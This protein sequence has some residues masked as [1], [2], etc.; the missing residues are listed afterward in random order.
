MSGAPV[1]PAFDGVRAVTWHAWTVAQ[2]Y[3]QVETVVRNYPNVVQGI[4]S[5][6]DG[7]Q[8]LDRRETS[9]PLTELF[10][11]DKPIYLTAMPIR[12]TPFPDKLT[13]S[14]A[15]EYWLRDGYDNE[16]NR[17]GREETKSIYGPV[18]SWNVSGVRS[19]S[20]LFRHHCYRNQGSFGT[21]F[22]VDGNEFDISKW[23]TKGVTDMSSAF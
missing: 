15:I 3:E 10:P 20:Y 16:E 18:Y 6:L 21:A 5:L 12:T 9:I 14:N 11:A 7:S 17:A 8:L 19:L 4:V 2:L 23:W 1:S 22:M 13:L